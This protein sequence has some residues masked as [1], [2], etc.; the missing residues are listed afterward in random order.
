MAVFVFLHF[1]KIFFPELEMSQIRDECSVCFLQSLTASISKIAEWR[2][3]PAHQ[4]H[5][6]N[7][8]FGTQTWIPRLKMLNTYENNMKQM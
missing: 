5:D 6:K 1:L 4:E 2:G 3:P 7:M 8:T